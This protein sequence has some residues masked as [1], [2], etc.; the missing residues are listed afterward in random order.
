MLKRNYLWGEKVNQNKKLLKTMTYLYEASENSQHSF[1]YMEICFGLMVPLI[2]TL[3]LLCCRGVIGRMHV[4]VF[5]F[6]K[7]SA[8]CYHL[9]QIIKDSVVLITHWYQQGEIILE[10]HSLCVLSAFE[11]TQM[12][13]HFVQVQ[14]REEEEW[15]IMNSRG[16]GDT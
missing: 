5:V 8:P 6:K 4:Y 7:L 14:I 3:L 12:S 16:W 13:S 11:D 9:W 15:C 2:I 10:W 1:L